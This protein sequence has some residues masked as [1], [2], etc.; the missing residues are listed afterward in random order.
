MPQPHGPTPG[1]KTMHTNNNDSQNTYNPPIKIEDLPV[2][3]GK[4]TDIKG[5]PIYMP[6]E[7]VRGESTP[8]RP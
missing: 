4:D 8:R 2:E 6:I 5:G 3:D 1:V 7:G